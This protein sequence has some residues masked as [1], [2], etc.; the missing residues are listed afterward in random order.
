MWVL[1]FTGFGPGLPVRSGRH[2]VFDIGDP[3]EER[4]RYVTTLGA[5][6]YRINR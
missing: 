1:T 2:F 5:V 3:P 4:E 6:S